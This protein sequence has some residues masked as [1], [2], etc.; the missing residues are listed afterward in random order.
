MKSQNER[1][2]VRVVEE[3]Y[4][5]TIT[6]GTNRKKLETKSAQSVTYKNDGPS[7]E[8]EIGRERERERQM[9]RGETEREKERK[10]ET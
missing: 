2:L 4:V 7:G 6:F 8:A 3:I 5:T 10:R 1:L 9:E